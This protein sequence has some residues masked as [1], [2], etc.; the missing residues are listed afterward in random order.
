MIRSKCVKIRKIEA[1]RLLRRLLRENLVRKELKIQYDGEYVRVPV[2]HDSMPFGLETESTAFEPR[3]LPSSPSIRA[4]EFLRNEKNLEPF[5]DKFIILGRALVVKSSRFPGFS[6]D[7]LKVIAREFDVDSIYIDHGIRHTVLREPMISLMYGPGGETSH[8]E[9]GIVYSFDPE[10]IMFSPGNVNVRV[11]E[12][13]QNLDNMV[14]LDMFAGIGYF[15]LQVGKHSQ[16]S[17]VYSCELNPTAFGFLLKN[18]ERNSLEDAIVPLPGDCRVVSGGITADYILMGHFDSADFLSGA[19]LRSRNGTI[20]NLHVLIPT[21]RLDTYWETIQKR[22]LALGFILDLVKQKRIKSY[23][24]HM[25][26]MSVIMRVFNH[27][28]P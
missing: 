10:K 15:S 22:A 12:A 11:S 23:G 21:E 1:N 24:P 13:R 26:H 25:W 6:R 5:P 17:V 28:D 20:I 14:I 18:V 4:S 9:N 8:R 2:N 16:N 19:L 3:R 7:E 27:P